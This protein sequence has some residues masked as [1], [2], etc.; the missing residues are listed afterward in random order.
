M[1]ALCCVQSTWSGEGLFSR[2]EVSEKRVS[3]FDLEHIS[4]PLTEQNCFFIVSKFTVTIV[5]TATIEK[6]R[7][8]Q[9]LDLL[10]C[11]LKNLA[12]V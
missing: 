7:I 1:R 11:S 5:T 2:H 3:L 8:L 12:T 9:K 10:A 6:R 4:K